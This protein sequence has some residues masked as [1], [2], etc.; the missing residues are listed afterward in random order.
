M[1]DQKKLNLKLINDL[2]E[3]KAFS[4]VSSMNN[5]KKSEFQGSQHLEG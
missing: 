2:E 1:G 5:T 3:R 4:L